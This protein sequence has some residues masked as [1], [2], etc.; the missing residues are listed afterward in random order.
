MQD[1]LRCN[2]FIPQYRW[3]REQSSPTFEWWEKTQ[4]LDRRKEKNSEVYIRLS[5]LQSV[6]KLR[7]VQSLLQHG[8][9]SRFKIRRFLTKFSVRALRYILES[10]SSKLR[11]FVLKNVRKSFS[12]KLFS[13]L[14]S[15]FI[16]RINIERLEIHVTEYIDS[17]IF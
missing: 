15:Q 16:N 7:R 6:P 3:L 8:Q 10:H 14:V 12:Q 9:E 17:E 4:F 1:R 11:N 2:F 13:K 5:Q